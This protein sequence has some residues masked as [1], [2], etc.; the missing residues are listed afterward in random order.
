M[1]NTLIKNVTASEPRLAPAAGTL[2][3]LRT[4]KSLWVGTAL[5]F[6]LLGVSGGVRYWRDRQFQTL[7]EESKTSPFPLKELPATLGTWHQVEGSEATLDPEIARIA[8]SSDHLIRNYIDGKSGETATV[9]VLYGLAQIVFAHT[10]D[11][12]FP[13]AGF[14][15]VTPGR[16]VN[17]PIA[18]ST[19]PARFRAGIYSKD[20]AGTGIYEESFHSF[21]NN[22][23]WWSE[24]GQHWKS[25]RY[26]PGMFKVQVQRRISGIQ[27]KDSPLE[28]LAGKIVEEIERRLAEGQAGGKKLR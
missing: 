27:T 23:N 28:G 20:L 9:M 7:S 2:R 26:H 14:R 24:V 5:V 3:T 10:P 21:R 13:A 11:V 25:F 16:D 1:E 15:P 12:C 19:R 6:V 17:I 22:G 18:G 4:G 8:G